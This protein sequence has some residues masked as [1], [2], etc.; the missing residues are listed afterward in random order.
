MFAHEYGHDLGLPDHYDTSGG[1]ENGV[2]WWT[3]MGQSRV[4]APE[5]QAIGTRPADLGAWDKLQLGWLDYEIVPAGQT[6]TLDLGPHEYN[7]AKAQGVVV[8]LPQ[9]T[10]VTDLGAPAAGT[11]QWWSGTGDDYEATLTRQ[12]DVP[13]GSPTLSFQARWNIEDCGPDPCDYAFVEVDDGTGWK[14]I[15]GSITKAAEGNGIDGQSGWVPATF[16]LSAYAG[17]TVGL[18]L[19]YRT[20]G[21]VQGQDRG[22]GRRLLRRRVRAHRRAS[23]TAP[24]TATTAGRRTASRPSAPRSPS[25]STTTTSPRTGRT[26]RSTSTCGPGRTTSASRTGPDWVE[27]FPYQDGLLVSY[28]DTSFS[29][30]NTSEHPGNGEVLPIDANPRPIYRLDGKPWRPRIQGYDAPFSLQKSDSFTLHAQETG[31]ASYIRGQ[32]AV[33]VFDDRRSYWDPAM[34]TAGVKVPNEGVRIQVQRQEG[35]SMRIRISS[36]GGTRGS[37]AARTPRTARRRRS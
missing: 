34:P 5:D 13:A 17:K 36:T 23:P 24:R 26:R 27:H 3:I 28:W 2:N 35:T 7:S 30:N 25:C 29:D 15:P 21:A 1:G 14:A 8:P 16:D 12:V 19:H 4:S 37:A 32:A 11:K 20:D 18:R 31:Q 6:R 22:R 10:V 9:K 33:P